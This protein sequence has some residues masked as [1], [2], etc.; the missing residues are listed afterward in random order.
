MSRRNIELVL[1]LVAAPVVALLFVMIAINEGQQVNVDSLSVPI[2][3]FA[4][5]VVAHLAV[6]KLAPGAD[7]ALLPLAFGLSGIG[8]AFI[9]RIAPFTDAPNM[10][11]G[12]VVWLFV[13]VACMIVV[14][15]IMA[16]C[17]LL[18][19]FVPFAFL[20][21]GF[22]SGLSGFHLSLQSFYSEYDLN[23]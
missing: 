9:T 8:I 12:Q 19:W 17:K 1:L 3:I 18:T 11:Q 7:P 22:F 23:Y 15:V 6:R 14:L 4:A 16:A 21:G 5:F 2:G 20:T 13:G 10:A